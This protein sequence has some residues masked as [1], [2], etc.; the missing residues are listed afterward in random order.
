[1]I[2]LREYSTPAFSISEYELAPKISGRLDTTDSI[3]SAEQF[4][5]LSLLRRFLAEL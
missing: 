5:A 4:L 3:W 2:L 1:M